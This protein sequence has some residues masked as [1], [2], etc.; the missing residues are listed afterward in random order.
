[1]AMTLKD[2][3]AE[4]KSLGHEKVR[5]QNKKRGAGDN[6]FGVKHGDIR[7]VAAKIKTNHELAIA[8]WASGNLD[9]RLLAI[10]LMKPDSLSLEELDRMV[11]SA[12]DANVAD[13]LNS[14]VVKNHP[15]R[16]SLREKWMKDKNP[17]AAR[18]GWN[19][20][21]SRI[22]KSPEGLDLPGLLDRIEVEMAKAPEAVQWTMNFCL[23]GIG[24]HFP[25]HRKRALA[26][27]EKL[28]IYR[29]YPVSKG[30]TSPFAPIWIN[31]MVKR[32][33]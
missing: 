30:C 26:I 28:G 6:Q 8:L 25:K 17:W 13:W 33:G 21:S 2:T 11:R 19:L 10:L 1:M 18:A 31:E 32:Q 29:D 14:Y 7:K 9:A 16:E 22:G 15:D 3:L 27:G 23:A 12:D 5:A 24:I 4:L 20:T